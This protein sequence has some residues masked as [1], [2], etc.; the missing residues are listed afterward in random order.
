MKRYAVAV[1]L[2]ASSVRF[3]EGKL[4][5]GRITY[6]VV[7]QIPN[8]P[9]ET[10]LG[11]SWNIDTLLGIC[12]DAETHAK[13]LPG[14]T[15]GIDSWGVDHG[16]VDECGALMQA[17]VCYRHPMHG[18]VFEEMRALRPRLFALTGIQHQPFNTFYQL[19]ARARQRPDLK[20]PGVRWL[21]L[22]ELLGHLLGA[23]AGH[24]MTQASTT[25]LLGVDGQ[26]SEE[27]FELAGWPVAEE[28]P[29]PP[30]QLVGN[31]SEGVP[32]AR[33]A[34][35]DTASAVCGLGTLGEHQAFLSAGT[36][37]LLGTL[38]ETPLATTQAE[39]ENLTNE[40]AA[41]GRVRLLDNIPGF[42]VIN[43]LHD[44]LGVGVPVSE[45]L[46]KADATVEDRIDVFHPSLFNPESMVAAVASLSP[47]PPKSEPAWA[48]MALMS[49]VD[50]TSHKL[51][52]LQKL[53]GRRFTEIRVAG[54][55]SASE[56]FCRLLAERSGRTVLA[57]PQEATV[58]GNLGVQFVAQG[59]I[60]SFEEMGA[61]IK[62]SL[63]V[64]RY[65][66]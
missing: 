26:W 3:A 13:T 21:I 64:R 49:L 46:T 2:G 54:G 45:W 35:H 12:R 41:D 4:E 42:F 11:P 53:T 29:Q 8:E 22:P 61:V 6:R 7:R 36:W 30:A 60:G 43:R 32:V 57:G 23:P 27:A 33:V 10:E 5:D 63:E 15:M 18:R 1:D 51:D 9:I 20:R 24:E 19:A 40:R 31:T 47:H 25:Q 66:G 55:G 65:G 16:F 48:G 37:S 58:L 50:A 14:A 62:A 44:E 28:Q 52:S 56:A 17:P 39:E 59:A 34:G 38:I